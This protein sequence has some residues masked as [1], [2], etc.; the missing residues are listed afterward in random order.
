MKTWMAA[1]AGLAMTVSAPA[2][3]QNFEPFAGLQLGYD[4]ANF[5]GANAAGTVTRDVNGQ[6][7]VLGVF[8]GARYWLTP[9]WAIGGEAELNLSQTKG[10]ARMP[11]LNGLDHEIS[12][13]LALTVNFAYAMSNRLRLTFGGGFARANFESTVSDGTGEISSVSKS[14]SG[15]TFN[16]GFER[17]F[18]ARTFWRGQWVLSRY[19][20]VEFLDGDAGTIKTS[21]QVIRFGLGTRF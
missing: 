20:D 12:T 10:G 1:L 17:D 7:F 16:V 14:A 6:G 9:K 4:R 13:P 21:S 5:E 11:N 8:G 15:T 19:G 18:S 3:A 2:L